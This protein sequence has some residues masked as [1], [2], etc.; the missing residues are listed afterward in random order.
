VPSIM[1]PRP[2]LCRTRAGIFLRRYGLGE[3]LVMPGFGLLFNKSF[4]KRA[5]IH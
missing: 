2:V 4:K 3:C 5:F 1:N